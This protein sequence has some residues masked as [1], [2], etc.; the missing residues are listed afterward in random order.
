MP[1]LIL[2]LATIINI[3]VHTNFQKMSCKCGTNFKARNKDLFI[4]LLAQHLW[5]IIGEQDLGKTGDSICRNGNTVE[6]K[7]W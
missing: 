4:K 3:W 2:R 7:Q 5:S 1:S 6:D